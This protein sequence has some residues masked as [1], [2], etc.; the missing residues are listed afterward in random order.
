MESSATGLSTLLVLMS[1]SEAQERDVPPL[2]PYPDAIVVNWS[3]KEMA[4]WMEVEL[5]GHHCEGPIR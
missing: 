4:V 3:C 2:S 1:W 5:E